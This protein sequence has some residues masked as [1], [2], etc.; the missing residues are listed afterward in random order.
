M[1]LIISFV[2]RAPSSVRCLPSVHL[3]PPPSALRPPSSILYSSCSGLRPSP[4]IFHASPFVLHPS[5]FIFYHP[6]SVLRPPSSILC[7]PSSALQPPSCLL[8]SILHPS[9]VFQTSSFVYS[10]LRP[11]RSVLSS[12]L[13]PPSFI[14][15]LLL[16]PPPP[17]LL[18]LLLLRLLLLLLLR[19]LLLLLFSFSVLHPSS[20]GLHYVLGPSS[21]V[22]RPSSFVFNA[23]SFVAHLPSSVSRLPSSSVLRLSSSSVLWEHIIVQHHSLSNR[24]FSLNSEAVQVLGPS[25]S[26]KKTCQNNRLFLEPRKC[27]IPKCSTD[28]E[29]AKNKR[30]LVFAKDWQILRL[31]EY[32]FWKF[33]KFIFLGGIFELPHNA[34]VPCHTFQ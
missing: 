31:T 9:F 32:V 6:S 19:L 20:S 2:F 13:R 18:L 22:L 1:S 34:R 17:R 11:V 24:A 27:K 16:L 4:F 8:S 30:K 25:R 7:P 14:L 10:V 5:A 12:F 15:L 33:S 23:S 29:S 26:T 21:F 3:R 28:F